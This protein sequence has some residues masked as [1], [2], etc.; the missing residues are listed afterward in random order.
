MK[1]HYKI[2]PKDIK[3]I[4][5]NAIQTTPEIQ[6]RNRLMNANTPVILFILLFLAS[7]NETI[8]GRIMSSLFHMFIL[9]FVIIPFL[10][11][12][13]VSLVSWIDR[14][15]YL[16]EFYIGE[17]EVNLDENEITINTKQGPKTYRWE[18]VLRVEE[19]EFRYFFYFTNNTFFLVKKKPDNLSN[20]EINEF[21]DFIQKCR[22]EYTNYRIKA[23]KFPVLPL[24]LRIILLA[25]YLMVYVGNPLYQIWTN[26]LN[27]VEDEVYGLFESV[28]D[29]NSKPVIKE[30]LT[31]EQIDNVR[32][33][34]YRIIDETNST[35]NK[36]SKLIGLVSQAEEQYLQKYHVPNEKTN[37]FYSGE[38][39]NWKVE[40]FGIEII[41]DRF[42]TIEG[43]LSMKNQT[44]FLADYLDVKFEIKIK[45]K[46]T[47]VY[48]S[49]TLSSDVPY[50]LNS[51]LN[52]A[53]NTTG[54]ISWLMNLT[55]KDGEP[56]KFEDIE[57]ISLLVQWKGQNEKVFM[58]ERIELRES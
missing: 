20:E 52:L 15:K 12:L 7:T 22:K 9:S 11:Q 50:T 8:Y 25:I 13:I 17:R 31:P 3:A 40:N 51:D 37:R 56:V 47:K 21:N 36:K 2:E 14:R 38:S 34:L 41:F 4:Q 44:E 18:D 32:H 23:K 19:D 33:K 35:S 5:K 24:S 6:K 49:K 29:E 27:E 46:N 43:T 54:K 28:G 1:V 10:D 39:E 58:V 55:N 45:G 57:Q 42:R 48:H 26:P 16:N 30:T 53:E